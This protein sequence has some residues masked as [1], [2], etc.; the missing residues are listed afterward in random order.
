MPSRFR[1]RTPRIVPSTI[2]PLKF[3]RRV[4]HFTRK[5]RKHVIRNPLFAKSGL[6][7]VPTFP[8]FPSRQQDAEPGV[9]K[10]CFQ[11]VE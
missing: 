1:F 3:C 6:G 5:S 8:E 4:A 7:N 10:T 2:A 9:I 11:L